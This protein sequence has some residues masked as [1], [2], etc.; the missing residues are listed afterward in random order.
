[1]RILHILN[2][3]NTMGNGIVNL[4]VD[5]A[6][7]QGQLG[8]TVAVA[9]GGG[10]YLTLLESAGIEHFPFEQCLQPGPLRRSLF[11]NIRTVTGALLHFRRIIARFDPHIVHCHMVTGTII[12]R[13]CRFNSRYKLVA[14]IHNVHQP[15]SSWCKLADKAIGVSEGAARAMRNWGFRESKIAVVR[16]GVLGT[17]RLSQE[18]PHM[19]LKQPAILTVGGLWARKNIDGL[20]EAFDQVAH[21]FSNAHL[22]IVG[23]G[24]RAEYEQLAQ[25]SQASARIHFE[26]FKSDPR[27]YMRAAEIFVLASHRESFGLVLQEAR[28]A[29]AAIIGTNVDGI[30]EALDGGRAG[31]LVSPGNTKELAAAM[32]LLLSDEDARKSLQRAARENLNDCSTINM[33]RE[34]QAVYTKLLSGTPNRLIS[35]LIH[36]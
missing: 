28:Q 19:E 18:I 33:G 4:A 32:R 31:L 25:R 34:V 13:A 23:D 10:G 26:G 8:N 6:C 20:I 5:L 36:D 30:P 12:A 15:S 16:N 27:P 24:M 29:G 22:Y 11:R 7:A 14:H 21:D 17:K 1:M 2:D 9:S 3:V 35:E